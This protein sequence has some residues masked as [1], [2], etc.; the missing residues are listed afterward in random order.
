MGSTVVLHVAP[1]QPCA[2]VFFCDGLL[3][4]FQEQNDSSMI[5][6]QVVALALLAM[7]TILLASQRRHRA[8]ANDH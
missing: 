5:V 7:K 2:I 8:H 4:S 1:L 3:F 6:V